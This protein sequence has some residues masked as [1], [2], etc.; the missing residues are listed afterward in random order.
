MGWR[1]APGRSH[2]L[3]GGAALA[4]SMARICLVAVRPPRREHRRLRSPRRL[5]AHL[6]LG[7]LLAA[8][9][10]Q[11]GCGTSTGNAAVAQAA[12]ATS[13][14]DT[15][16]MRQTTSLS[17]GGRSLTL[18]SDGEVDTRRRLA[19]SIMD[20]SSLR[21]FGPTQV[22]A[23]G[24]AAGLKGDLVV[25]HGKLDFRLGLLRNALTRVLH[26][27]PGE[28]AQLDLATLGRTVGIDLGSIVNRAT[29][30]RDEAVGYLKALTGNLHQLGAET[31][32]GTATTHYR[33]ILDYDHLPAGSIPPAQRQSLT[34]IAQLLKRTGA[35]TKVPV[36]VWIGQDHLVRREAFA[37]SINGT[38]TTT[39][40]DRSDY[41]KP[42]DV[43]VPAKTYDLLQVID[44]VAPGALSRLRA[45]SG[46]P[47]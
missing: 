36:D 26:R 34:Q 7:A 6:A 37:Q 30:S 40:I 3:A 10:V 2:R 46:A 22:D 20:L 16:R 32:D 13:R 12:D 15:F 28:W 43:P 47:R 41:G 31:I 38:Q 8:A 27:D 18:V 35:S 21:T 33:G 44:Q 11:A 23:L 1:R 17:V 5:L 4:V 42:V 39:T 19:H 45:L 24:G 14:Q 9:V 25:D 29:P